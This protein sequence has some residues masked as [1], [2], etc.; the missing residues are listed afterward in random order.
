MKRRWWATHAVAVGLLASTG[1]TIGTESA[2]A[3]P[4]SPATSAPAEHTG[5]ELA[6][7]NRALVRRWAGSHPFSNVRVAA[8]L[9]LRNDRGDEAIAKFLAPGGGYDYARKRAATTRERNLAFCRRVLAT[10]TPEFSPEVHA[11]AQRALNGT[12]TDR[13]NFAA[14]GY[15][16][17]KALD[18]AHREASQTA[19][20]TIAEVDREFVRQHAA[21]DPGAQ[22]RAAAS[23]ALR[24]GATDADIREFYGFGW[25]TGASLDLEGYRI[26]SA[27]AEAVRRATLSRLVAAA[28]AAERALESA[29]D[30]ASA[31]AEAQRA[32][33][34]VSEHAA[35]AQT[36]WLR[37]QESAAAQ[38]ANWKSVAQAAQEAASG[39]W[40]TMAG[41]AETNHQAWFAEQTTAGEQAEMWT[42][43]LERAHLSEY[44]V[45]H[46]AE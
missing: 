37:E 41:N 2:W 12:D 24:P 33:Q 35:H 29:A 8:W 23:W 14:S 22:V 19:K 18:R 4:T 34:A 45:A 7:A 26:A 10:H 20:Q 30:A 39:S 38:A 21:H 13:A 3:A 43:I 27:D 28:E 16:A 46:G 15:E 40:K 1:V 32:W 31:R 6:A 42:R 5:I 25:A 36:A 11:E 17:A 9:A 44:R